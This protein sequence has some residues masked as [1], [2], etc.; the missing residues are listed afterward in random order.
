MSKISVMIKLSVNICFDFVDVI[1][2]GADVDDVAFLVVGD[3]F[4]LEHLLVLFVLSSTG[5]LLTLINIHT[6]SEPVMGEY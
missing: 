1:L 6:Y 2:E 4:G 5:C 3:P